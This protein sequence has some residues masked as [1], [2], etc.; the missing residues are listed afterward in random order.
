MSRFDP[1]TY[2]DRLAIDASARRIRA[3]E[4]GKLAAAGAAWLESQ[5]RKFPGRSTSCA[6]VV[7][8]LSHRHSM[9]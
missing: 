1:T 7:S 8:A 6:A 9:R 4:L 5:R 2:P 3:E